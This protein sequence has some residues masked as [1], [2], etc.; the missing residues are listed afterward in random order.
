MSWKSFA[1]PKASVDQ[2]FA[3]LTSR[4]AS[5]AA[6]SGP[7][8]KSAARGEWGEAKQVADAA[9]CNGLTA[10]AASPHLRN[11]LRGVPLPPYLLAPRFTETANESQLGGEE[12]RRKARAALQRGIAEGEA[13]TLQPAVALRAAEP[14]ALC[15]LTL[16]R[17]KAVWLE[18]ADGR[19]VAAAELDRRNTIQRQFEAGVVGGGGKEGRGWR[20]VCAPQPAGAAAELHPRSPRVVGCGPRPAAR[21]QRRPRRAEPA[22]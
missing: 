20:L 11:V 6:G 5:R 7:A 21:G 18:A 16:R 15:W 13:L 8:W 12:V 1:A 4:G 17:R 10:E 14:H 2:L 22:P 19:Q 3:G 9:G